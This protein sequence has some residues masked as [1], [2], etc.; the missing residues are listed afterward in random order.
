MQ[1]SPILRC[2]LVSTGSPC[3]G[4]ASVDEHTQANAI[5]W[6]P[7]ASAH[8]A[9]LRA[10]VSTVEERV[11]IAKPMGS[12]ST[13]TLSPTPPPTAAGRLLT[14]I[15]LRSVLQYC[16]VSDP[17][18][19]LVAYSALEAWMKR[20][21]SIMQLLSQPTAGDDQTMMRDVAVAA[22]SVMQFVN[23]SWDVRHPLKPRLVR[24][25][26]IAIYREFLV[27]YALSNAPITVVG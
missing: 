22:E 7:A 18:M 23:T 5:R 11:L 16:R 17:M 12:S 13:H 8:L 26:L 1:T 14:D 6:G 21:A 19:R 10:V 3:A 27:P 20:S 25:C 15:I 2:L 24:P 9:V 4:A